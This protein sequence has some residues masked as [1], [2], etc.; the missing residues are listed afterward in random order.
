MMRGV[1]DAGRELDAY[2]AVGDHAAL[3]RAGLFVAEGRLVVER[4]L[5]DGRFRMHSVAV[6]APAAAARCIASSFMSVA[7]TVAPVNAVRIWTAI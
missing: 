4:L 2:R 5:E 3:E 6:T 7:I 1:T